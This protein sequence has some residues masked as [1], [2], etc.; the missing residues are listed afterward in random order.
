MK[1]YTPDGHHVGD[2]DLAVWPA[3]RLVGKSGK[4]WPMA[5]LVYEGGIIDDLGYE[6][7]LETCPAWF[8]PTL[9]TDEEWQPLEVD[10]ISAEFDGGVETR[11]E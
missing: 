10:W 8:T 7:L 11:L 4:V 3:A 9:E 1:L 6:H 5:R 2:V